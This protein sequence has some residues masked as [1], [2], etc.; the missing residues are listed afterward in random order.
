MCWESRVAACRDC[1]SE[2][3]T[4]LSWSASSS[5]NSAAGSSV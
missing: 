3:K 2:R 4:F 5:R 1:G